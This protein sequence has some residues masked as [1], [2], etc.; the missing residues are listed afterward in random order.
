MTLAEQFR[1]EGLLEGLQKG[2]QEALLVV[3]DVRFGRVPAGHAET[4]SSVSVLERL[5]AL[6]RAAL[7]NSNQF[8]PIRTNWKQGVAAQMRMKIPLR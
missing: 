5:E 3:L 4:L 8:E 2:R 6:H 7:T 1:Q